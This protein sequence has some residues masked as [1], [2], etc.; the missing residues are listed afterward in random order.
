MY[1][2][3]LYVWEI[4]N[5][6][7]IYSMISLATNQEVIRNLII[8]HNYPLRMLI[9]KLLCKSNINHNNLFRCHEFEKNRWQNCCVLKLELFP[10]HTFVL[11]LLHPGEIDKTENKAYHYWSNE[12]R[13]LS[14]GASHG[15]RTYHAITSPLTG[16]IDIDTNKDNTT[17][18]HNQY[19]IFYVMRHGQQKQ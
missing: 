16:H 15:N 19:S 2:V 1:N 18:H 6:Y 12:S 11:T 10:N 7:Y 8:T 17:N 4:I 9:M 3:L 13:Q 14:L 5:L